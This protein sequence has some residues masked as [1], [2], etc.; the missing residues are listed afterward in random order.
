MI[1]TEVTNMVHHYKHYRQFN[2]LRKYLQIGCLSKKKV[3][4]LPNRL[5]CSSV[6]QHLSRMYK[7]LGSIIKTLG[8]NY[9]V[10][11]QFH[12]WVGVPKRSKSRDLKRYFYPSTLLI[13]FTVVLVMT[14]GR[15]I[16][17]S[18]NQQ[19]NEQCVPN[20]RTIE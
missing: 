8:R 4:E 10:I 16:K 13:L 1:V 9:H 19:M 12:F 6:A 3:Q 7:A 17:P 15:E 5:G 18:T 11:Q 2:W 20:R 14:A